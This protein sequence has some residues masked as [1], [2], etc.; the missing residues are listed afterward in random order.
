[1]LLKSIFKKE[2]YE[3]NRK[4]ITEFIDEIDSPSSAPGG[5]NVL[6]FIG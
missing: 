3:I 5:E 6:A 4:K 1:L 2:K